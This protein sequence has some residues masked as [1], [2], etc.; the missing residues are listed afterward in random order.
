MN[1]NKVIIIVV[2]SLSLCLSCAHV[3]ER[4]F[5]RFPMTEVGIDVPRRS[6][7][8]GD[9]TLSGVMASDC[10]VRDSIII[11]TSRTGSLFSISDLNG[12]LNGE[13]CRRGRAWNEPLSALPLAETYM[14]DDD[15]YR[16]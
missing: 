4:D 6:L 8:I 1:K 3:D 12:N 11:A 15:L 2:F 14:R 10:I 16:T 7:L 13:Y 9:D 5:F